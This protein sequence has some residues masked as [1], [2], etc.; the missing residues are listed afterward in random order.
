[1]QL[2]VIAAGKKMPDWVEQAVNDFSKRMPRDYQLTLHTI[3]VAR[4]GK[5]ADIAR[6]CQR[7]GE[8]MLAAC[9]KGDIIVALDVKGQMVST[10]ELAHRLNRWHD[11]GDNLSLLIG[12]PDG[13]A[14]DC[15]AA[16]RWHWS[17]SPL[18]L[19]HPLARVVVVEQLYRAWSIIQGHPYHRE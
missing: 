3:P 4:R 15:L 9:N 8:Q 1:M 13:L 12:G 7:E 19:P 18:T 17:L 10:P 14:P 11:Q 6:L 16:A 2:S 5:N